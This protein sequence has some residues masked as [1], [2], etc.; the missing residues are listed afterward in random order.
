MYVLSYLVY[1]E[2]VLMHELSSSG[3]FRAEMNN[4]ASNYKFPGSNLHK[5]ILILSGVT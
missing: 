2:S 3:N 5:V 1:A 4:F